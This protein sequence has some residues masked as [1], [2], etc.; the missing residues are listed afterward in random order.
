MICIIQYGEDINNLLFM[1][2]MFFIMHVIHE[3]STYVHRCLHMSLSDKMI[4]IHKSNIAVRNREPPIQC[5]YVAYHFCLFL[6]K[7]SSM[8]MHES[9]GHTLP[10]HFNILLRNIWN[11]CSVL[12]SSA[13]NTCC[14]WIFIC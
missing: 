7:D 11:I 6:K 8:F 9:T 13:A 5:S 12:I 1:I 3:I 2:P 4:N 14:P 10:L